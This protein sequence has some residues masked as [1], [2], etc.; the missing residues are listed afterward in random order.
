[1]NLIIY[2]FVKNIIEE[3]VL[4]KKLPTSKNKRQ[5]TI[6][7]KSVLF[8]ENL[9]YHA[10]NKA[11]FRKEITKLIESY[12]F[13]YL[14]IMFHSIWEWRASTPVQF[15]AILGMTWFRGISLKG[16]L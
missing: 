4:A 12:L 15:P 9:L 14:S 3:K 5:E 2:I 11:L 6:R 7:I 8:L 16:W 10:K 13:Q 1:M